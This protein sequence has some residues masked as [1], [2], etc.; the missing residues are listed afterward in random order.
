MKSS[1]SRS[2]PGR[3]ALV[4]LALLGSVSLL[5]GG[6]TAGAVRT[7]HEKD[8]NLDIARRVHA[9]LAAAGVPVVMTRTSDRRVTLASRMAIANNRPVDAFVSIHNNGSSNGSAHGTEVYRSIKGGGSAVLGSAVAD[10]LR[11]SP[12]LPTSVKARRGDHGD[13][14]YQLRNAKMPAI[15]VEGAYVTNRSDARM[16]GSAAFRQ[17]LADSI[18]A[19]ILDYQRTLT[20]QPLPSTATPT[21][22]TTPLV[23]APAGAAGS[24]VNSRTVSLAWDASPAAV[25]YNVYRDGTLLGS[26]SS[27]PLSGAR[28]SFTD[29]W[30]APGQRYTYEIASA[31]S[32]EA[33]S[34]ESAP[35]LVTVRTPPI[36][37]ALDAGHG[38]SDP[39]AIGSY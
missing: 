30:A 25:A 24:A 28:L 20:A 16:L 38:G 17:R 11:R 10:R 31:L 19:G 36:V 23:G 8:L 21:R 27:T 22:V 1:R 5:V 18:A 12:G 39:G 13:Y 7:L 37:V 9:R 3:R 14:Y 35:A 29:V 6:S 4:A 34:V 2:R 33:V 26:V 15:I 32:L